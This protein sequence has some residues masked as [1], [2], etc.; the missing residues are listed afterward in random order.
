MVGV[1]LFW[2]HYRSGK[3]DLN[4][5]LKVTLSGSSGSPSGSPSGS[6]SGSTVEVFEAVSVTLR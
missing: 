2:D 4:T 5:Y 6:T 3:F 1:T